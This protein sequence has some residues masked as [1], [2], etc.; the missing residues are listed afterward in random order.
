[1]GEGGRS[2]RYGTEMPVRGRSAGG[3]SSDP[4][5]PSK[6]DGPDETLRVEY[7]P[8]DAPPVSA[9]SRSN[10]ASVHY[11]MTP[12]PAWKDAGLA[13]AVPLRQLMPQPVVETWTVNDDPV[14]ETDG[15]VRTSST[16]HVI[17]GTIE[18]PECDDES[19][20]ECA[21]HDAYIAMIDHLS[22]RGFFPIRI[23]SSVPRIHAPEG[24][25]ERYRAFCR[26]RAEAIETR[27]GQG[28]GRDLCAS[29][30]IGSRSGGPTLHFLAARSPGEHIE[31]PRQMSAYDYPER[32]GPRS[33]SFARATVA[34][35]E[36]GA[37]LF[38]SGT[39]SIVGCE[40]LHEDDL[41]AQFEETSR[42]LASVG[43]S[44]FPTTSER[45]T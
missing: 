17:F 24:G 41:L 5:R 21:V 27:C 20:F 38:I 7:V 33:P 35:N 15:P 29:T 25:L 10:L 45:G 4:N 1:M 36:L 11:G 42:N 31:N 37:C 34:P 6:P 14:V 28:F 30:V 12:T 18:P 22:T 9:G 8:A 3:G 26:A 16:E 40:S 44:A 23:W 19:G 39:A 13:I 43:E 32:Y 2:L